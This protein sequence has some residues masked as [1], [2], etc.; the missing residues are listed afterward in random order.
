MEGV[1]SD[2]LT[3]K[4]EVTEVN[5]LVKLYIETFLSSWNEE[6]S[7][8]LLTESLDELDTLF[9]TFL[10]TTHTYMLPKDMTELLVDRIHRTLTLDVEE[11][12]ELCINCLLSLVELWHISRET[13][14]D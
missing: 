10:G 6:V 12:C 1:S 3:H 11:T 4:D 8:E 5:S 13:W 9:K 2:K 14:P 7:V